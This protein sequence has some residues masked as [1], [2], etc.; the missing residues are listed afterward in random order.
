MNVFGKIVDIRK[1]RWANRQESW[2]LVPTMGFLHEGHLSLVR[3]AKAENDRVAVSIF[4]N[5]TQFNESSD[6]DAYPRDLQRDLAM[7]KAE[8]VDLVWTPTIEDAYPTGYQTNVTVTDITTK[9]E[10]ASRPGH[11]QGVTTVVAKLF[12]VFQPDRAYFGQKDA[13]QVAVIQQMVRDLNFNLNIVVCPIERDEHGLALSSR[14][15]RLSED[16]RKR[17]LCLSQALRSA[18]AAYNDGE[19]NCTTL[20]L[21]MT[22]HI[23]NVAGSKIDYISIADRMS[24]DEIEII[25]NGALLS[26]A[27]FIDDI[28]LIDNMI[29]E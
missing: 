22:A 5:P 13:Q 9:L 16:G 24:L 7:L 14:N 26:M 15:S 12:N 4:V 11:F 20:K 6:L 1:A 17:A 23:N 28:R 3:R 21:M 27:V 8:G 19:K 25:E 18:V 10:G 2:G 29:I